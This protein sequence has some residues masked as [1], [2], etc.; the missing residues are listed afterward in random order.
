MKRQSRFKGLLSVVAISTMSFAGASAASADAHVLAESQDATARGTTSNA[1]AAGTTPDDLADRVAAAVAEAAPIAISAAELESG[2]DGATAALDGGGEV[3][4]PIDPI[5]GVHVMAAGGIDS[6]SFSLPGAAQLGDGAV[7]DDGSLTYPGSATTPSINLIAADDLIRVS[8]VIDA[9]TQTERFDYDFDSGATVEIQEDGSA[10]AYVVESVVDP[11]TGATAPAEKVIAEVAAPWAKDAN[12]TD[13]PTHYEASGSRLTQVVDHQ[14]DDY[15]YPIVADPT[16]DRPNVFQYRLRFN[17]A[18]TATIASG[19]AGVIASV[20]CG[21][22][23]P[24]CVV[25]GGSVWWN[26]SVAQNSNPKRCVQITATQPYIYPGVLWWVDTYS[27]GP[28]R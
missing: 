14:D 10:V 21:V 15:A 12:G 1:R 5:S 16:L 8:V 18:E 6:M 19:G 9:A 7:A 2:P 23:A 24:V 3:V 22:M 4:L 26:A 28:C 20:G 17:R 27:G 11:T 13:V 25:A